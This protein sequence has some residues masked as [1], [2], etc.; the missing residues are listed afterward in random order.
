MKHNINFLTSQLLVETLVKLGLKHVCLSPGSRNTPVTLAFARNER[1]EKKVFVDER[2]SAFFALGIAKA[3]GLP[4]AVVCTS[5]TAAAEVYPAIVEAYS[6][7]V[8]LIV[9]TADRPEYLKNTG[10][11]QTINQINIYSANCDH[12]FDPGLPESSLSYLRG[13]VELSNIAFSR[14]LH[15]VKG[16]VH[17]NLPFEKPLEPS[18]YN[19][20]VSESDLNSLRSLMN[21]TRQHKS[22]SLQKDFA[23]ENS[24]GMLSNQKTVIILANKQYDFEFLKKIAQFSKDQNIP[25]CLEA[26]VDVPVPLKN[27]FVQNLGNMLQS[28][29]FVDQFNPDKIIIFGRNPVSKNLERYLNSCD[30]P[31]FVVNTKGENFGKAATNKKIIRMDENDFIE[32][33]TTHEI[34]PSKSGEKFYQRIHKSDEIFSKELLDAFKKKSLDSEVEAMALL[35]SIVS[36]AQDVPVFVSNSL[37]I[38][39]LDFLKQFFPNPVYSNRGAS[40]IDGIISTAAGIASAKNS[41]LL[42]IIGDLSFHYDSNS[43]HFLKKYNIP[44]LII[45]MNN[46]G[47]SIF[48]YL[49]IYSKSDEFDTYFKADTEIDFTSLV[50]AYGLK[51]RNVNSVDLLKTCINA[52]F[53]NP[54]PT[55][56]ELKFDSIKSKEKKDK[57]KIR[58][59]EVFEKNLLFP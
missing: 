29:K 34:Y 11:N 2:S 47:G 17:I 53:D 9:I 59:L 51:Y 14:T 23:D 1:I 20:E 31:L 38:R 25:V 36:I 15:P 46:C 43:L 58:I 45:L 27:T 7:Q 41:P 55:V 19:C 42:L 5:G 50:I 54:S 22:E 48:E 6:A 35:A 8:P 49:P 28:P 44:L 12:F 30:V 52:F 21:L 13:I 39:D 40:G 4:V 10:S 32:S 33:I 18:S 24:F 26:T 3:T 16:P 56:L 37:P 57:L